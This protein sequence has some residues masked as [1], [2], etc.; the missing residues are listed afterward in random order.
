[1]SSISQYKNYLWDYLE[2][3]H[4]LNNQKQFFRCLNPE[5]EDVHPSMHYSS[6]YNICKCFSCGACYDI[7]DLVGLD[8]NLSNFKEQILKVQ[9]LYGNYIPVKTE[10]KNNIN[11]KNIDYTNYFKKCSS[12][13]D[14]CDYLIKREIDPKLFKKYNIGFDEKNN[15]IIF[16]I[17]K[18]CYF[19]RSVNSNNKF[20]SPGKSYLWNEEL[21]NDSDE[22]TLIYVTESIIDSLSLQTIDSDIKTIS[23]NGVTNYNRLLKIVKEKNYKGSFVIVFDNDRV[24]EIYQNILK[25]ELAKLNVN[26]FFNTLISNI[27]DEKCKDINDALV[28]FK[29]ILIKN[30]NYFNDNYKKIICKKEMGDIQI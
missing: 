5:H 9:E 17:N 4:D 13:I 18:N 10:I 25:E 11:E 29:D 14:K 1:M 15:M 7:F 2:K 28:N 16:P 19:G 3:Y 8:F 21:L 26:S 20:K 27:C 12:Q 23:L 24:G 6:K 22:N 30:Y